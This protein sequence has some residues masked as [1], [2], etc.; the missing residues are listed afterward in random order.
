MTGVA[1]NNRP[2]GF[3]L[4]ELLA[5]IAIF[6][7]LATLMYGGIATI[8]RD[9]EIIMERLDELAQLQRTAT[10]LHRD[11]T[12]LVPRDVRG[13]LGRDREFAVYTDTANDFVVRLSRGGW[14]NPAARRQRGTLQRVEYRIEDNVLYRD[15]WPVM[16][17]VLGMDA[18]SQKLIEG[19]LEF[20]VEFLDEADLWQP[21]WPPRNA[22]NML[23]DQLPHAVRYRL[24][25]ENFGEIRRM[26]EVV[27]K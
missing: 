14:N 12:Q 8:V 15:Y 10:A 2:S 20:E 5:A 9:R 19:V 7:I 3:T 24:E 26:V 13:V 16:D 22:S 1:A 23:P 18:Q 11:F 21:I 25:L 27:S 6:G 17:R 4:I